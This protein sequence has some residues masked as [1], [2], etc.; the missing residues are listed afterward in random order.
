MT[1]TEA[2]DY[3]WMTIC[4]NE[5]YLSTYGQHQCLDWEEKSHPTLRDAFCE[6]QKHLQPVSRH[7]MFDG[8]GDI[9]RFSAH[10]Y[11]EALI[12]VLNPPERW[13]RQLWVLNAPEYLALKAGAKADERTVLDSATE[14]GCRKHSADRSR[15]RKRRSKDTIQKT[16][17]N[18][19][20]ETILSVLLHEH[21]CISGD[22]VNDPLSQ[23]ELKQR[24]IDK[25]SRFSQPTISRAM[26]KLMAEVPLYSGMTGMAKYEKLCENSEI[27]T[28]LSGLQVRLN[29]YLE[30]GLHDKFERSDEHIDQYHDMGY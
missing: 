4:C 8:P 15:R 22:P 17:F 30:R 28:E 26:E 24:L 3:F 23:S 20:A 13:F 14:F 25:N 1:A 11:H 16:L 12:G 21:G 27:C 29:K 19:S 7:R 9:E 2:F 6:V 5:E 10:S 18:N